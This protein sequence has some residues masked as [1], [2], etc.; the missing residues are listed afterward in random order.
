MGV[1]ADALQQPHFVG[2]DAVDGI[3]QRRQVGGGLRLLPI[4]VGGRAFADPYQLLELH[5][6]QLGR[7]EVLPRDRHQLLI[8]GDAEVGLSHIERDRLSRA[9]E[10]QV[11]RGS[12]ILCTYP[13]EYMASAVPRVNPDATVALYSALATHAGA[14]RPVTV[15]DP[16]VA[17]DVLVHRNGSRYV[18]IASHADEALTVK[19]T[20]AAAG[21]YEQPLGLTPLGE[22]EIADRVTLHPFGIKIFKITE[23]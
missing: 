21:N 6:T 14:R 19:P 15:A 10:R 18:V 16:D 13:L 7:G 8:E 4:E 9:G 12:L 2:L 11:G 1:Q 23:S 20:L 3:L 17:C 5:H 22:T